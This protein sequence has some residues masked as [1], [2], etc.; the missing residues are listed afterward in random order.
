MAERAFLSLPFPRA[1]TCAATCQS[2]PP[3]KGFRPG[4]PCHGAFQAKAAA[5]A[6]GAEGGCSWASWASWASSSPPALEPYPQDCL[7]GLAA[8]LPGSGQES[9]PASPPCGGGGGG[10]CCCCCCCRRRGLKPDRSSSTGPQ[11]HPLPEGA[12]RRRRLHEEKL[13]LHLPSL[14]KYPHTILN[15]PLF[16]MDVRWMLCLWEASSSERS[17]HAP[18]SS[19]GKEVSALGPCPTLRLLLT[20]LLIKVGGAPSQAERARCELEDQGS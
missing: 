20:R 5:A 12:P 10:C 3:E 7:H 2:L 18:S 17:L 14:G 16:S 8:A 6:A 1:H 15:P 13:S 4:R 19:R 11:P 9:L